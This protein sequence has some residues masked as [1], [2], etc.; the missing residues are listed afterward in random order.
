MMIQM[1]LLAWATVM[2][3]VFVDEGLVI[4]DRG[5]ANGVAL[6]WELQLVAGRAGANGNRRTHL[7]TR[8]DASELASCVWQTRCRAA[9]GSES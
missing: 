1:A 6:A 4:L 5:G 7:L 8:L 3:W 9:Y 2:P